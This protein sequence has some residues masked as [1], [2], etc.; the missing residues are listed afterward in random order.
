M[1]RATVD[2]L[3][4]RGHRVSW[5]GPALG[6][7]ARGRLLHLPRAK[8]VWNELDFRGVDGIAHLAGPHPG[9]HLDTSELQRSAEYH[10]TLLSKVTEAG[11]QRFVMVSVVSNP[12]VE[13][14]P[15][16]KL[17]VAAETAL[18]RSA[19]PATVFRA[20]WLYGPND[21]FLTRLW[22]WVR[23]RRTLL[24]PALLD[25]PL[26]LCNERVLAAAIVTALERAPAQ[27][28]I[29]EAATTSAIA[30]RELIEQL[31]LIVRG[32]LPKIVPVPT[33]AFY[34]RGPLRLVGLIPVRSPMWALLEGGLTCATTAFE[35]DFNVD[36]LPPRRAL[37]EFVRELNSGSRQAG[38]HM[39]RSR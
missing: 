29:Y 9:V 25:A 19:V 27:L 10:N 34:V 22:K 38:R 3:L 16:V 37:I 35:R 11:I 31:G 2:L 20:P 14:L 32:G 24:A 8:A 12:R 33:K 28:R 17:K 30:L 26:Q 6:G 39:S 21:D 18:Q 1:A 36:V 15:F 13:Q 4:A 7:I 23:W 5:S